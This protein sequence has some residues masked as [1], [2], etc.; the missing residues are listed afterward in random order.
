MYEQI[1]QAYGKTEI[2]NAQL[3]DQV[4]VLRMA[5]AN[6]NEQLIAMKGA[7]ESFYGNVQRLDNIEELRTMLC[8]EED[9]RP[10]NEDESEEERKLLPT[11]VDRFLSAFN[12]SRKN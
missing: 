8:I 2:A 5:N 7:I 6:L 10:A 1:S 11:L 4:S 12:L 9:A 3:E